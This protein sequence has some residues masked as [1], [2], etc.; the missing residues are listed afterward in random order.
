MR[1][2][3]NGATSLQAA[4]QK[5]NDELDG[6]TS[7][8]KKNDDK[9]QMAEF[10]SSIQDV[11]DAPRGESLP[12]FSSEGGAEMYTVKAAKPSWA[13]QYPL[14]MNYKQMEALIAGV[15]GVIGTSEAVQNRVAQMLPQFYS[16]A[17]GKISVTGMAVLVIIVAVIF[18]FGK[19]MIMN[20]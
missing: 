14:G 13:K 12:N 7:L 10:S 1:D 8:Q 6:A 17:T 15:A 16:E 4:S 9:E 3:F 5:K 18:Y 11:M 19:Q 2:E 20:R